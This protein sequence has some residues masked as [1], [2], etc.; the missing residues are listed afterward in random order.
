MMQPPID[1]EVSESIRRLSKSAAVSEPDESSREAA[2]RTGGVP[3]YADLGGVLVVAPDGAVLRF[4]PEADEV[5]VVNDERWRMLALQ[6]GA[7]K[8]SE[9]ESLRPRRPL[10]AVVCQLCSGS[11]VVA[12]DIRCGECFGLGWVAP[13]G[14]R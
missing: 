9:L 4:D 3:V 8:F 14:V 2:A 10:S 6:S 1:P 7:Q 13:S 12:V 11:G 5:S